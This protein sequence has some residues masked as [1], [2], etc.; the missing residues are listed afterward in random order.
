MSLRRWNK[1]HTPQTDVLCAEQHDDINKSENTAESKQTRPPLLPS[2]FAIGLMAGWGGG[3]AGSHGSGRRADRSIHLFAAGS[4]V[5]AC[6]LPAYLLSGKL[7]VVVSF[8]SD[9]HHARFVHDLLDD[10]SALADD[11]A[12]TAEKHMKM[13]RW[14]GFIAVF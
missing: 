13:N 5:P 8:D 3:C 10:F 1:L 2:S 4:V 6:P 7:F 11:F 9:T 12:W 14:S